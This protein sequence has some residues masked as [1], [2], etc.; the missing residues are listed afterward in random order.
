MVSRLA[1]RRPMKSYHS[2]KKTEERSGVGGIRPRSTLVGMSLK[3]ENGV[4]RRQPARYVLLWPVTLMLHEMRD[5]KR[6]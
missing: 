4:L 6:R 1:A 5:D 3:T 2:I